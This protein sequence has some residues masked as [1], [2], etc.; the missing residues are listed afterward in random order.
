MA[1]LEREASYDSSEPTSMTNSSTQEGELTIQGPEELQ[2]KD[3]VGEEEQMHQQEDEEDEDEDKTLATTPDEEGKEKVA[4]TVPA[5][6]E[7]PDKEFS[8]D[9]MVL[10]RQKLEEVRS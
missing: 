7:T 8:V 10:L 1:Q 6:D 9:D 3:D 5:F 2:R 4:T